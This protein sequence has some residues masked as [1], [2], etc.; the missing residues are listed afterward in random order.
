MPMKHTEA[1]REAVSGLITVKTGEVKSLGALPNAPVRVHH[2]VGHVPNAPLVGATSNDPVLS[3]TG[4]DLMLKLRVFVPVATSSP[5]QMNGI[6]A[7]MTSP[8][9]TPAVEYAVM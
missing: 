3:V 1:T 2:P 8:A 9:A 7:L 4:L 6:T 5:C